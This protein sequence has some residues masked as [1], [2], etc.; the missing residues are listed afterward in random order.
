MDE[1]I[2]SYRFVAGHIYK[3]A[4]SFNNPQKAVELA[5]Q[6]RDENHVFVTKT[7]CGSW[8]VYWRARSNDVDCTIKL[9]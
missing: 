7:S 2:E 3:L 4:E 5:K 8:A 1:Q 6:M 9:T